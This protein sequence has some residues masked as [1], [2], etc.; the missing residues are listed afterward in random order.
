M[1]K[2]STALSG[3]APSEKSLA[4]EPLALLEAGWDDIVG[5]QVARNSH[6]TRIADGALLITTRSSAWSHQLNLLGEHVLRAVAARVP[7]AGVTQLRFRVGRLP[8]RH[9]PPGRRGAPAQVRDALER[10]E[11]VSA[12]QALL[13]FR[14][15]VE[16]TNRSKRALGWTACAGCGSLVA[17]GPDLCAACAVA[18]VK[19]RG[20]AAARLLFEA[21][22]LGYAGTAALVPGLKE[23]EYETIRG[24]L[25]TRWWGIL[26]QAR[27]TKRLSRD[28]RERLVASS[29]I[30][31]RSKIPPEDIM[32]A[33]VRGVLGDELHDLIFAEQ[34]KA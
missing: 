21:P 2:L 7:K 3:W 10:P 6:P 15:A 11:A 27:D 12:E 30:L 13:R 9:G 28:G 5:S 18:A 1:L 33:T 20:E 26:V 23:E 34:R 19:G 24:Q 32:P 29:Y 8:Q 22:W 25:L 16:R 4:R 17:P 14:E 31:L